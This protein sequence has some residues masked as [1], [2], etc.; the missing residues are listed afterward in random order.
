MDQIIESVKNHI[1]IHRIIFKDVTPNFPPENEDDNIE[2][3][4]KLID[5]NISRLNRLNTQMNYRL[6]NGDGIA[7][8]II[9]IKDDGTCLGLSVKDMIISLKALIDI[10]NLNKKDILKMRFLELYKINKDQYISIIRIKKMLKNK[11]PITRIC[12]IGDNNTGK[13]TLIGVLKTGMSDNGKGNIRK[14]VIKH[15]HEVQS[16]NTSSITKNI[17]GFDKD[18]NLYD[19]DLH[20]CNKIINLID[21]AGR[22]NYYKITL[23]GLTSQKPNYVII[24]ISAVNKISIEL[25]YLIQICYVMKIPIIC[26]LTKM[27][28]IDSHQVGNVM[29]YIKNIF[30]KPI[31]KI[32]KIKKNYKISNKN[33]L[34]IKISNVNKLRIDVLKD[35][36]FKLEYKPSYLPLNGCKFIIDDIF[37]ICNYG[38]IISGIQ[39]GKSL[40]I[41]NNLF[42]GPDDKSNFHNITI[43]TIHLNYMNINNVNFDEQVCISLQ[44]SI[45]QNIKGMMIV[46]KIPQLTNTFYI[47]V[48]FVN[49]SSVLFTIKYYKVFINNIVQIVN[50]K[51]FNKDYSKLKCEFRGKKEVVING[52]YVIFK[53]KNI[54]GVGIINI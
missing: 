30:K 48:K 12:L 25:Q 6:L 4:W 53:Y 42:I 49:D 23:L 24:T 11:S 50:I 44:E 20:K 17:F 19:Y 31:V 37:N 38:Q 40:N 51:E 7:K 9:G 36:L 10:V 8:Y 13:S 18:K 15:Q 27:D 5:K 14:Y 28:L 52:D 32:N 39:L 46:D 45:D 1:N 29:K 16:G 3:K 54:I 34:L 2:Y 35:V 26:L 43:D 47:N 22:L 41:N 21:L 33:I